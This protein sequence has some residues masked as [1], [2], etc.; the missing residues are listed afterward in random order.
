MIP[1][2][3]FHIKKPFMRIIYI[4]SGV[5]SLFCITKGF[6]IRGG[7][8]QPGNALKSRGAQVKSRSFN[9]SHNC[10]ITVP[11][12]NYAPPQHFQTILHLDI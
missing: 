9:I 3:E 7:E 11:S 10:I 6:R 2:H 12:N 5:I 1:D 8:H 4:E